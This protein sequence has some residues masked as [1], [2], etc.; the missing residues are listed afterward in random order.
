MLVKLPDLKFHESKFSGSGILM[1]LKTNGQTERQ[2]RHRE[3]NRSTLAT[4]HCN[5]PKMTSEIAF[6]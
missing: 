4:F 5:S 6:L 2:T 3:A 1:F